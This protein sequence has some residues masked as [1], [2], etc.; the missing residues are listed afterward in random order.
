MIVAIPCP[1]PMHIVAGRRPRSSSSWH[2][3]AHKRP[4]IMPSGCPSAIAPPLTF[5]RS[6]SSRALDAREGLA[7][8]RL[9]ELDEIEVVHFQA[10]ASQGLAV[11]GTGP[12]PMSAGS[13][14]ASAG[15]PRGPAAAAAAGELG[16]ADEHRRR[17]IIHPEE[18]PAVT[19]RR[20]GEGRPQSRQ[21]LDGGVGARVLVRRRRRLALGLRHHDGTR[22]SP[23]RPAST[24]ATARREPQREL[25][26]PLTGHGIALGEVLGGFAHRV[27]E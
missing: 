3:V 18:L 20:A 9:V 25:V 8:E 19:D 2:S 22:S 26:L 7:R 10:G 21:R 13:T 16:R 17:A 11:A 15:R 23:K 12:I 24:A 27:R 6:G 5:T 14:P 1:T 4:P